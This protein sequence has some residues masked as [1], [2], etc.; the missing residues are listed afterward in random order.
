MA[1]EPRWPEGWHQERRGPVA[2]RAVMA[3]L[4]ALSGA[5]SGCSRQSSWQ[6]PGRE[7]QVFRLLVGQL[8]WHH[9]PRRGRGKGLSI[10]KREPRFPGPC[11]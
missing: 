1:T 3:V 5:C 4:G 6:N 7:T 8:S 10:R 2:P 9:L 11:L